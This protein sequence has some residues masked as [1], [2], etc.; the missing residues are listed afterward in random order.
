MPGKNGLVLRAAQVLFR[1]MFLHQ[2]AD[3]EVFRMFEQKAGT[4]AVQRRA[5][6]RL[7]LHKC[8]QAQRASDTSG[9]GSVNEN[10][11]AS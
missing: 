9:A 2:Q 5:H 7:A 3:L 6:H 4:S 11:N 10:M 1:P 8:P